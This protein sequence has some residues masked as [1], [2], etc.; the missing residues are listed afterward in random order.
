MNSQDLN[1]TYQMKVET[2]KGIV[3][4]HEG[5]NDGRVAFLSN[6]DKHFCTG[7]S[8]LLILDSP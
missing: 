4:L 6:E 2:P 5:W 7:C 8:I 1:E 3:I